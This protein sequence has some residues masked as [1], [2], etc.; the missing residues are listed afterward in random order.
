MSSRTRRIALGAW[1]VL[2]AAL[3]TPAIAE[4]PE[5]DL[6]SAMSV[7][8]KVKS[9]ELGGDAAY[10]SLMTTQSS[11]D[12]LIEANPD[13]YKAYDTRARVKMTYGQYAG[14]VRDFQAAVDAY[15]R[16]PPRFPDPKI[17]FS[18]SDRAEIQYER[19]GYLDPA[20]DSLLSGQTLLKELVV[21]IE[22]IRGGRSGKAWDDLESTIRQA[23]IAINRNLLSA[24]LEH[25]S[26]KDEAVVAF[27]HAIEV[28]PDD[29][30]V[31][32]KYGDLL[33]REKRNQEA[34]E[35]YGFALTLAEG[36]VTPHCRLGGVHRIL[37]NGKLNLD[38]KG[39]AKAHFNQAV[40]NWEK[41][42]TASPDNADV[43]LNM[44]NMSREI[45]NKK[46]ESAFQ[47]RLDKVWGR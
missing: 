46:K 24:F 18:I 40:E 27:E 44:V 6:A 45:E 19:L 21:E 29:Y 15:K 33:V 35:A 20:I 2:A 34:L 38:D 47:A 41:C 28:L 16:T 1:L 30:D 42:L 37:M 14:A 13:S 17:A 12:K 8:E 26:R 10:E 5:A 43:L 31:R 25:P 3:A 4:V 23:R 36:D 32:L 11:L 9:G 39:G 7:I 22:K